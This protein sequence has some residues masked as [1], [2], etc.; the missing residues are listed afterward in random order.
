MVMKLM[1]EDARDIFMNYL[2]EGST[3][4]ISAPIVD[5]GGEGLDNRLQE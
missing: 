4:Q 2:K 5:T 1:C 3:F